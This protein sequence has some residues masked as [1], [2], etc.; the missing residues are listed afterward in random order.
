MRA[1]TPGELGWTTRPHA[2][3]EPPERIDLPTGAVVN[4]PAGTPLQ[5]VNHGRDELT[6]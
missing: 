1:L 2:D 4:V 5:T 3:G 6:V